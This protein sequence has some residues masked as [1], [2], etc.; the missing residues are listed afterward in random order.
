MMG[1]TNLI[2]LPSTRGWISQPWLLLAKEIFLLPIKK[3]VLQHA[4]FSCSW[5]QAGVWGLEGH[6]ACALAVCLLDCVLV[7]F[8]RN[9]ELFPV[10]TVLSPIRG[11]EHLCPTCCR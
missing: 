11:K 10:I 6:E 5:L 7:C 3:C 4:L 9:E 2:A 1:K 8:H